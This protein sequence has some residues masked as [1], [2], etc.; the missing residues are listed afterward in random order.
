MSSN[1]KDTAI[2]N[3]GFINNGGEKNVYNQTIKKDFEDRHVTKTDLKNIQN[4]IPLNYLVTIQIPQSYPEVFTYANEIKDRL[5]TLGYKVELEE[6][7]MLTS[8]Y[9][10]R[11]YIELHNN[12]SVAIMSIIPQ[13]H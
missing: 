4:E 5:K 3:N 2:I 10:D 1:K 13:R 6:F 11:F 8:P 7:A 9:R 12:D